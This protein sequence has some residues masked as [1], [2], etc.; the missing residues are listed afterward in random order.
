MH[1]L[2]V[3]D[4]RF[5]L[6][7]GTG[8]SLPA[9]SAEA[10]P[11]Q[12]PFQPCSPYTRCTPPYSHGCET[13][14]LTALAFPSC[15]CWPLEDSAGESGGC[16]C[17][18]RSALTLPQTCPPGLL[19]RRGLSRPLLFSSEESPVLEFQF[20]SWFLKDLRKGKYLCFKYPLPFALSFSW[21]GSYGPAPAG[22]HVEHLV[23]SFH[24]DSPVLILFVVVVAW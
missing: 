15:A 5:S 18:G 12:L 20:V 9:A 4:G 24:L 2:H 19:L 16:P 6:R 3:S 17:C 22:V 8:S 10:V 23:I 11:A 1:I 14:S 21:S 13:A 7:T